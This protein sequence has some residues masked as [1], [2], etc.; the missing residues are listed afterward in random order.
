MV[1]DGFVC[2]ARKNVPGN[3]EN[4]VI[5]FKQDGLFEGIVLIK[6]ITLRQTVIS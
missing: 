3:I 2:K 1:N 6:T 5:A 4:V